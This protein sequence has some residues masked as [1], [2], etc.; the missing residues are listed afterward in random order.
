MTIFLFANHKISLYYFRLHLLTNYTN[1]IY[2]N[3]VTNCMRKL[4]LRSRS[5]LF[6]LFR[7]RDDGG[8]SGNFSVRIAGKKRE[9]DPSRYFNDLKSI[10]SKAID[11]AK[12]FERR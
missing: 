5:S 1:R 6:S 2:Q 9:R 4:C 10:L 7:D 8:I 11:R 3:N 12:V